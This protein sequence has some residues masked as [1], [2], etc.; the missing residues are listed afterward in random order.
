MLDVD[1]LN[2]GLGRVKMVRGWWGRYHG[3]SVT[4]L[5]NYERYG[6]LECGR[7]V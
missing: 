3:L 4:M 2:V 6:F 1:S 5:W 7:D